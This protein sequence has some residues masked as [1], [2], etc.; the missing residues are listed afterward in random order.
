MAAPEHVQ[1]DLAAKPRTGLSL[2]PA[3]RWDGDR[4]GA[5]G[6]AQPT[7][8][9]FGHP[10][11]DQ[12]YALVLAETLEDELVLGPEEHVEDAQAGCLGVALRRASIFGRAPVIHDLRVAFTIWGFLGQAPEELVAF[13]QPLF[14]ACAHHYEDRR[15]IVDL[16]P[17]G[18]L[19]LVR[20]EVLRRFPGDW[21]ALLG[22]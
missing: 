20:A 19:R 18:T 15:A 13:R 12:G 1:S 14:Q 10:G 21:K 11:P 22:R 6:A 2:P 3:R 7:G 5:L 9:G 4:P 17:E 16:V 8:S